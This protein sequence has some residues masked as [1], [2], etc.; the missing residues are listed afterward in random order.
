MKKVGEYYTMEREMPAAMRR[1]HGSQDSWL[2]QAGEAPLL[3]VPHKRAALLGAH[4][5]WVLGLPHRPRDRVKVSRPWNA[6]R[7]DGWQL[8]GA[9]GSKWNYSNSRQ[10]L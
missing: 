9:Y 1:I 5:R 6:R 7:D 8:R 10:L 2:G 3:G 4:H